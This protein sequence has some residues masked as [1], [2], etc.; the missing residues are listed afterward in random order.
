M[1]TV[2]VNTGSD[3]IGLGIGLMLAAWAFFAMTD[4][5][6]KWLVLAGLPATQIAFMRYFVAFLLSV[7]AGLRRGPLF[8][9]GSRSDLTLVIVRGLLLVL[10]TVLN[11]IALGYLPLSVTSTIM[12]SAPI[13]VTVLAIPLLG[14][15]VGPWRWGAVL[16]GFA[17]VLTVI[18]PFGADFH[19]ATILILI[20]ATGL[21]LFSILTRKLS[22]RI[23]PQTMQIYMGAL[24]TGVLLP[25]VA[26]TWTAPDTVLGWALLI[27]VGIWAW[28]GHE[29]FS[30]AHIHAE[31]GVLMP[32]SYS[33]ILYM[34]LSGF[35]VF[36]VAP[37][38]MTLVGASI[39]VVSG[40]VIWWREARTRRSHVV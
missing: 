27:G 29:L 17:G 14:E 31:A 13:I 26:F 40:L 11:F 24:G 33:F 18:R 10:A 20:N 34:T 25:V 6:V 3:R 19:W 2:A 30:R 37:D 8:A 28:I 32:F 7:G 39:I 22:G 4:T 23:T 12:N 16:L 38:G 21:A 15:K 35:V 5:S 9:R 1:A 36:G